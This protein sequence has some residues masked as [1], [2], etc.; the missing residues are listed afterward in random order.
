M[1]TT[2][3]ERK[4]GKNKKMNLK[5]MMSMALAKLKSLMSASLSWMKMKLQSL[6]SLAMSLLQKLKL[7]EQKE[8]QVVKNKVIQLKSRVRKKSP[9]KK[10]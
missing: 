8:E 4:K 6:K 5:N 9:P 10:K 2:L 1:R 3:R 7:L